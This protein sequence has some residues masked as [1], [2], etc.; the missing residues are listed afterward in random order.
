MKLELDYD[1]LAK[2]FFQNGV[3]VY[4]TET[5]YGLGG[6]ALSSDVVERVYQIKGREENKPVIILVKDYSVA[7]SLADVDQYKD[8]LNQYW[9]G[10]LTGVFFARKSFPKGVISLNNTIAIRVSP[11]PFIQALFGYID[12]P[13]ISTSAN[14]S[15][16]PSCHSINEVRKSLG[17]TASLVDYYVDYGELPQSSPST[18]VN[19][20]QNPPTVL[21][22][23]EIKLKI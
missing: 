4:P 1:D 13:I 18:I 7:A 8:I 16:L 19:F 20:T 14:R 17:E 22:Q 11:H 23:G 2:A 15:G 3:I 9:P 10:K 21:R 5:V 12:F 6:N